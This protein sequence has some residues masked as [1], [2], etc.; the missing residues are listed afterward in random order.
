MN[1]GVEKDEKAR[2]P[3]QRKSITD[4]SGLKPI[5]WRSALPLPGK[6]SRPC[7]LFWVQSHNHCHT[8]PL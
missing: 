6:V 5:G 8:T 3:N 4:I 1:G 7:A 2:K